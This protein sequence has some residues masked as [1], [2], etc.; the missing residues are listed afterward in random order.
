MM[1][2]VSKCQLTI[3]LIFLVKQFFLHILNYVQHMCKSEKVKFIKKRALLHGK[4]KNISML[5][6]HNQGGKVGVTWVKTIN[7]KIS[8]FHAWLASTTSSL[9]LLILLRILGHWHLVSEIRPV[10]F[11][12]HGH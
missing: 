5:L 11:W 2:D 4:I 9:H 3:L 7:L 6:K 8:V 10:N 1:L 12:G